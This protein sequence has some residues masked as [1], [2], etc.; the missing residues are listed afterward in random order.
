MRMRNVV[1]AA[2][3][4]GSA[5]H[6]VV[7]LKKMANT[8]EHFTPEMM[9]RFFA[10]RLSGDEEA[11]ILIHIDDCAPCEEIFRR[12]SDDYELRRGIDSDKIV[13]VVFRFD[14]PDHEEIVA[15]VQGGL[16]AHKQGTV[17]AHLEDCAQCRLDVDGLRTS[18]HGAGSE[19][20]Y[21]GTNIT[22]LGK[23]IAR[24]VAAP[25]GVMACV[26]VLIAL[27]ISV[28]VGEQIWGV[29]ISPRTKDLIANT[30]LDGTN[31][32]P[33]SKNISSASTPQNMSGNHNEQQSSPTLPPKSV[34]AQ[35]ATID[36][37][38]VLR[39]RRQ[40][41]KNVIYDNGRGYSIDDRNV[42]EGHHDLPLSLRHDIAR[43][44]AG[45]IT[46]TSLPPALG[47]PGE[48]IT[49]SVDMDDEQNARPVKL[50][51][52]TNTRV[53]ENTLELGWYPLEEADGYQVMV[54][55][56]NSIKVW[57]SQI[58][59]ETAWKVTLPRRE[60]QPTLYRWKVIPYRGGRRLRT[61]FDPGANFELV[62]SEK[63]ASLID[64][65]KYSSRLALS[66]L[67]AKEGLYEKAEC[68][69]AH[70]QKKNPRSKVIRK[71]LRQVRLNKPAPLVELRCSQ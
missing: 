2:N 48:V 38:K 63:L 66:V 65:E 7:R 34:I 47:V 21:A 30:A 14:H 16:N 56:E 1:T 24:Q 13:N 52:P 22:T 51:H 59:S 69:L 27:L 5:R 68:E 10:K 67:Y 61:H 53:L 32:N 20:T 12:A 55:D 26:A 41:V 71:L 43:A 44:L 40:L 18:S 46:V 37:T 58:L 25:L 31:P 19:G 54:A 33:S 28:L 70:L 6:S 17:Q 4:L 36:K 62:S 64:A 50:K 3:K 11:Y 60:L 9:E 57:S 39:P 15:Y 42:L 49:R 35:V 8:T 29:R 23:V 45:R